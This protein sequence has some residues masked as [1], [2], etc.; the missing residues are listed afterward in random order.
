MNERSRYP[1]SPWH[2]PGNRYYYIYIGHQDTYTGPL[3]QALARALMSMSGMGTRQWA[4]AHRQVVQGAGF[5]AAFYHL[6]AFL[7]SGSMRAQR[8][9]NG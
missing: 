1:P 2:L 8:R 6:L 4:S 9:A 5:A 3:A 7:S